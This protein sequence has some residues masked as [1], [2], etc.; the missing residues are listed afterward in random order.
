MT[1]CHHLRTLCDDD[2]EYLVGGE[3]VARRVLSAHMDYT[4]L[5]PYLV[6]LG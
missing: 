1:K 2:V 3:Y 5:C 6:C 4:L